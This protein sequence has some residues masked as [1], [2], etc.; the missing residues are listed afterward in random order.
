MRIRNAPL[1]GFLAA[2]VTG[3]TAALA[4]D[5][6]VGLAGWAAAG[7]QPGRAVAAATT[8]IARHRYTDNPRLESREWDSVGAYR[9]IPAPDSRKSPFIRWWLRLCGGACRG[10]QAGALTLPDGRVRGRSPRRTSATSQARGV[11]SI[12]R[13]GGVETCCV[14][15][16]PGLWTAPHMTTRKLRPDSAVRRSS[17]RKPDAATL[18]VGAGYPMSPIHRSSHGGGLGG[19]GPRVSLGVTV[20]R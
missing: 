9:C 15:P 18:A 1:A 7:A 19:I 20:C 16:H 3:A 2:A 12:G 11:T 5:A 4:A 10:L 6:W 13:C 17:F 8:A 14:D